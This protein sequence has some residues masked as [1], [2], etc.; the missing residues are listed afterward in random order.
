MKRLLVIILLCAF[1]ASATACSF[2]R[3]STFQ[4]PMKESPDDIVFLRG[5]RAIRSVD[6]KAVNTGGL[7][8]VELLPGF[9]QLEWERCF[10]SSESESGYRYEKEGC[11][12]GQLCFEAK[13]GE[14]YSFVVDSDPDV[15]FFYAR[16]QRSAA[17]TSELIAGERA[18]TKHLRLPPTHVRLCDCATRRCGELY[19]CD[20]PSRAIPGSVIPKVAPEAA[21]KDRLPGSGKGWTKSREPLCRRAEAAEFSAAERSSGR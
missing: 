3:T 5:S 11:G 9:H 20:V 17:N 4:R 6:G 21:R 18:D 16:I 12:K 1:L 15:R 8:V 10:S 13:K 19:Q 2:W 7:S 14:L